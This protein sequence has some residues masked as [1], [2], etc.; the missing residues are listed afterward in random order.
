LWG[1]KSISKQVNNHEVSLT[2][3][4]HQH[5]KASTHILILDIAS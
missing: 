4:G 2:E 5:P 1:A 3:T